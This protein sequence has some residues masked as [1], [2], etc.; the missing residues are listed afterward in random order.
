ML[1]SRL[2]S[3]KTGTHFTYGLICNSF[4][5]NCDSFSLSCVLVV[6]VWIY[7]KTTLAIETKSAIHGT[8]FSRLSLRT[9][10]GLLDPQHTVSASLGRADCGR[11][12]LDD[13]TV[14][15]QGAGQGALDV[16]SAE[17]DAAC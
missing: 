17:G 13:P 15:G 1:I 9:A 4:N 14:N 10:V 12:P 7:V 16:L 8:S 5:F 2:D 3:K 6:L 11:F